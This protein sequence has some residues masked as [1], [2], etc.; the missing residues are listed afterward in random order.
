MNKR[1]NVLTIISILLNLVSFLNAQEKNSDSLFDLSLEELQDIEVSIASN[2]KTD[3]RRQPASITTI[4]KGEIRLSGARTLSEL[5]SIFVPGYLL[6]EDQDDTIAGFRGIVPDNNSKTMLLLNGTNLNT[7]WFWGPPD[8]IL[9]GLDMAFIERVEVIRGPGSVTLGQGALLGVINIVTNKSNATEANI[10]WDRGKDGLNRVTFD[11][12]YHFENTQA[13]AYFSNGQYDGQKLRAQGWADVRSEQGLTIFERLHGLKKSEYTNF[14]GNI[15]HK[16]LEFD[17]YHFEQQR[18]LYN[19][20][21]DRE[22]VKQTIDGFSGKYQYTVNENLKFKLSVRYT[23]DDYGLLSH[24]YNIQTDDRLAYENS[25]SGF[26]NIINSISGLANKTVEPGL[27]MGGTREIRKGGKF[28]VNWENLFKGNNLA[29]GIEHVKYEYGLTNSDGHNFIINEEI[30]RLGLVSDNSGGFIADG[31]INDNNTWVKPASIVINSFFL[32]DFYNINSKIDV[33]A[34]FRIDDHPNWGTQVSPRIGGFYDHNNKHLIRF[35]WQ[36]GFRGAVG[37]QFAGGFVQ[38]G[39]LAQD[40]F[41]VLNDLAQS[42]ADFNFDGIAA[43]DTGE[44]KPVEPETL[45]SYE[46]SYA[47]NYKNIKFDGVIFFNFIE[48]IIAAKANGYEGLVFG[49]KIGSDDIGTWNGNWY[50]QN[51]S[52]KLEQFGY[53]LEIEYKIGNMILAASQSHVEVL[54]ADPS[55]VGTYVLNNKKNAVYPEDVSRFHIRYSIPNKNGSWALQYNHMYYWGYDA[56]TTNKVSI[57]GNHIGNLG[58]SWS[59]SGAWDSLSLD[60][61]VKNVW[62]SDELYPINGTGNLSG[63]EGTPAVEKRTWWLSLGYRF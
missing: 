27:T 26:S 3:V 54:T 56:P 18:D 35:S 43:N 29:F 31:N 20:F 9:N 52:G 22:I 30:Q 61:I 51:Q 41:A 49:D 24:G 14:L 58:L 2:I 4:S 13:Y 17:A 46:L 37:V 34:A 6:V 57:D 28:Q 25:G 19:F 23:R 39:L 48:D 55:L 7:E 40:N 44:L 38:D 33:F 10:F 32:E 50:Y 47:Y 8:A 5:L 15:K 60:V 45:E 12:S 53:E 1:L 16:N 11:V 42:H 21:R 62:D 63:A 59:P 36:T